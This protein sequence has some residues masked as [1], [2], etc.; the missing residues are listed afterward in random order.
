MHDNDEEILSQ[1]SI[2]QIQ[3][4]NELLENRKNIYS[5]ES[6][7][8]CEDKKIRNED[9]NFSFKKHEINNTDRSDCERIKKVLEKN[10]NNIQKELNI[11]N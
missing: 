8:P 6:L 2:L 7:E 11:E 1:I 10:Y 5:N 4:F 9:L 3:K